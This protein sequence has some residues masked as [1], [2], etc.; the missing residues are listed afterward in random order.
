M[1]RTFIFLSLLLSS[2][3]RSADVSELS[4]F[5]M[6]TG[7]EIEAIHYGGIVGQQSETYRFSEKGDSVHVTV[8]SGLPWPRNDMD[9]LMVSAEQ[10]TEVK[11]RLHCIGQFHHEGE[12]IN[13]GCMPPWDQEYYIVSDFKRIRI[14]PSRTD[15][16]SIWEVIYQNKGL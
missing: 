10:F 3:N 9:E 4:A 1:I 2:C 11:E 13:S 6:G 7:F 15:T 8:L 5:L 16:C 14:F 12:P